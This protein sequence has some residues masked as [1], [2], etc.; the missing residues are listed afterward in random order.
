MDF[1]MEIV[2]AAMVLF[3]LFIIG[4]SYSR[5]IYNY[6]N[7]GRP[8]APWSSPAPFIGPIF[9]LVGLSA[10]SVDLSAW[11]LLLFALDP[12]TVIVVAGLPVL[13]LK[14]IHRS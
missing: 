4:C 9:V 6:R 14:L 7:R 3:G 5:Q 1:L 8:D 12:D 2:Y 13:F 11:S 10:L